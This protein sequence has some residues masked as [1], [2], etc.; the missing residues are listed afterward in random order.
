MPRVLITG[1]A[2]FV[3]SNLAKELLRRDYHVLG[4]D[5]LSHGF[6]RNIETLFKSKSFNFYKED[7]CNPDFI[8]KIGKKLDGIFHLAAYKIP[9]YGNALATLKI[10]IKGTENVLEAAK[11]NKCKVVFSS[12]SDVYGKNPILP[13]SEK[14]DLV[15]GETN[16]MRW[17]Y[18]VSKIYDEHLCFAYQE[19]FGLP[20][21]ILRYFG[22][23][24][25]HQNLT[26][27]GGPQS[28]FITAA[29][30]KEPLPI[31]GNGKQTRSFTYISDIVKATILAMENKGAVG[32][33]FNIGNKREINIIAL[34]RMTW[35]MIN[36]HKKPLLE[37]VSYKTF[38]K[39]YEDVSRRV[40]DIEK[41]EKIL[42]FIPQVELEEGLPLTIHWQR[43]FMKQG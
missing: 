22:G 36:P 27:W 21:V 11:K 35:K 32:E 24:G 3:G 12:T 25:P 31:H 37:F 28:V 10:N 29:L 42:N 43:K 5:N 18:A 20:I 16:V 40:P 9:R 19:E 23:Y 1:V 13:F 17:A 4:V 15:L 2:G 7:I 30:K 38:S 6:K 26:W 33:I 41:A 14:S 34:A 39:K 8:L